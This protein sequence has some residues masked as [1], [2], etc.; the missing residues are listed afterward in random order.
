MFT[1]LV[2]KKTVSL[3]LLVVLKF[4]LYLYNSLPVV[5]LNVHALVLVVSGTFVYTVGYT[6]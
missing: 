6:D 3:P 4:H 5:T 1:F 2:T